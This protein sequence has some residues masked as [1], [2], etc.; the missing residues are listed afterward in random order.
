MP[1]GAARLQSEEEANKLQN[2]LSTSHPDLYYWPSNSS[3]FS[4]GPTLSVVLPKCPTPGII[5]PN[6]LPLVFMKK[7]PYILHEE[8]RQRRLENVNTLELETKTMHCSLCHACSCG[9]HA[10]NTPPGHARQKG[11]WSYARPEE[12]GDFWDPGLAPRQ[13]LVMVQIETR[14]PHINLF[15]AGITV[16]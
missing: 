2:V 10:P 14:V 15:T 1:V 9:W 7:K 4:T 8:E 3:T 12:R 6:T 13:N 5:L 16:M 11:N